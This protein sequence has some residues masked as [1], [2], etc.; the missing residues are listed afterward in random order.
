MNNELISIIMPAYNAV[1]LIEETLDSVKNQTYTHWELIVV[2]DGSEDGTKD[3]VDKFK[4]S[5]IQNVTYFRNKVNK[6]LPATRNVAASLAKGNWFALL[7]SDDI[8]HPDHLLFLMLKAQ[9]NPDCDLIYSSHIRFSETIDNIIPDDNL[10]RK[11]ENLT[12]SLING[13][14]I[15][16]SGIMVSSKMY[17]LI[18]GFDATYRFAEDVNFIFRL[19]KKGCKFKYTGGSTLYY[20]FNLNGLSRDRQNMSY[21]LAKGYEELIDLE[22]IPKKIRYKAMADKWVISARMSRKTNSKMA[23]EAIKKAVKYKLT[24]KTLFYLV[25]IYITPNN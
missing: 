15:Q 22:E 17:S 4:S 14:I 20:R 1:H 5:V 7:D 24:L 25:F 2:E 6:G 21:Y 13:Y 9:E 12:I 10:S 16:P 11:G 8:W 23:K 18:D 3:I 19:L